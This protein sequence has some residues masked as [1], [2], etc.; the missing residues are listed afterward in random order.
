MLFLHSLA[1]LNLLK[2]LNFDPTCNVR[3]FLS[4][5]NFITVLFVILQEQIG[6]F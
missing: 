2:I 1:F 5:L 6:F 4:R 3:I